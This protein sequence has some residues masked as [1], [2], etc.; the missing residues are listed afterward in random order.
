[1]V[2]IEDIRRSERNDVLPIPISPY[3]I[4]FKHR[5][6]KISPERRKCA[7]ALQCGEASASSQ[8]K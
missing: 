7:E 2:Q 6:P 3:A 4:V 8:R 5:V 1:M